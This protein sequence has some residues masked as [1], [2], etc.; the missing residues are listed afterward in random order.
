M[1]ISSWA[2]KSRVCCKAGYEN[3]TV[4]YT[5]YFRHQQSMKIVMLYWTSRRS[6]KKHP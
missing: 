5:P 6:Y 1:Y 4:I 3:Y 2:L